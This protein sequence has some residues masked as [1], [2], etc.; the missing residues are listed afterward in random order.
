MPGVEI[1]LEDVSKSFGATAALAPITRRLRA[2]Q[3]TALVGPSGCGK[4]T[5]LRMIAGL[6]HPDSGIIKLGSEKPSTMA[7]RGA[8]AMAFQDPSL[9]PWRTVRANITLGAELAGTVD[10]QVDALIDLVGL[11][12]FGL[13]RPAELSGGMRQRAAIARALV[14]EPEVLL[15]DEPFGAV[16]AI[17]RSRLG[18]EL[19][20]IWR[21]RGTTAV[22]V[23]HSVDE[24]VQLADRILV[25]T[26]RPGRVVA[27]IDV[28][29]PEG[30]DGR[31]V[32]E[33]VFRDL[34][35]QVLD[36]L[37]KAA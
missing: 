34:A 4:S 33:R 5:L 22:L 6:E 16:D 2:G 17:T 11:T 13:H 18:K 7:S 14:S 32:R 8:L 27:D 30:G 28:D 26:P 24:A 35:G 23:T 31:D 3:T 20:P 15:L 36:A 10:P 37:E 21:G 12:G 9:L 29:L 1:E 25:L 19:P